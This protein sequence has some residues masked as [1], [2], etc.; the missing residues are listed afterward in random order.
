MAKEKKGSAEYNSG[1]I[2][3]RGGL[4][5]VRANASMY[6]GSTGVDGVWKYVGELL[7]NGVDEHLAGRNK[8]V[9]LH[10]DKDGSYWVLDQGQGIPQGIKEVQVHVNGKDIINKIPTMQAIFGE[11]HTSGKYRS[12]AYKNS[13]GTHGI[14]SKG[15]NATSEFFDVFTLFKGSWYS[16]GFK[17][18][19]ITSQVQK[20][21]SAP[22]GP[23]GKPLKGGT[24]I[25][26]KPD[27][28]IYSV[29]AFPPSMASEWAEITAYLNPG[30]GI[31]LSSAKGRKV[32][33]SKKGP[34]EYVDARIKKLEAE[35]VLKEVFE[36][37]SDVG[38]IVLAFTNAENHDVRGFTNGLSNKEGGTHVSSAIDGLYDALCQSLVK[39][40]KEKL[41]YAKAKK[42]DKGKK[43]VFKVSDLKEGVVGLVNAKLHKAEFSSQD[44]S[45]LT[46][47]RM[48][49]PFA[50]LVVTAGIDF[51]KKNP[52]AAVA[53]AERAGKLAA[54]KTNFAMS[55]KTLGELNKLKKKGMSTSYLAPSKG[56]KPAERE[57]FIVEG[58][59][60]GTPAKDARYK[61]Q[62]VLP[63][64]GK[65]KNV[66]AA[67]GD[68]G[69]DSEDILNIL[70]AIGYD[71]KSADPYSKLATGKLIFLADPDPDGHHINC[72]LLGLTYKYLPEAFERGM[73]YVAKTPEYYAIYKGKFYSGDG[74]LAL[75]KKLNADK[76]PTSVETIHIKGWGEIDPPVMRI[77][78]MNAATRTLI[79]INP[80]TDA[81]SEFYNLMSESPE[82]RRKLAGFT[83]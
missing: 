36:F 79:Q 3:I 10:V 51:F 11:L 32:Y 67:K 65:I 64:R 24:C 63:I 80:L 49:K 62:G 8:A 55:K 57:I 28:T 19:K 17:K 2:D 73:V 59:S 50:D 6:M 15:T 18:G 47:A 30:L 27:P 60:A 71:P 16:V 54:L 66:I 46:D 69:M 22:Q 82:S 70:A 12:D 20:L 68:K 44:K 39:A 23:D 76:V 9:M 34:I 14:G 38:E 83:E 26:C 81:D 48:G 52:K 4:A 40:G 42:G 72:L 61:H 43:T 58:E 21:K 74:A 56:T 35:R 53:L 45:K 29:K 41:V 37:K 13:I 75:R 5:G 7:D 25:H 77:L 33:L 78:A 1:S 31:I